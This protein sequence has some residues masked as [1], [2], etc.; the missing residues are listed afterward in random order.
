[1]IKI[2]FDP[3]NER[4]WYEEAADRTHFDTFV[5]ERLTQLESQLNGDEEGKGRYKF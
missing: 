3:R 2:Q 5:Q 1:M 4:K